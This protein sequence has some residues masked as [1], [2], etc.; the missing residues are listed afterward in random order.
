MTE[1]TQDGALALAGGDDVSQALSVIAEKNSSITQLAQHGRELHEQYKDVAF[2]VAT[3]AGMESAKAA[4]HQI[5]TEAR[6]PMQ[7]LQEEGSKMLGTMQRQFNARA[8][9]L[10]AEV[11]GYEKPID[12]QIKAEEQRKADIKAKAEAEEKLRVDTITA[13]IDAVRNAPLALV[14]ATAG[15]VAN[16]IAELRA[17]ADDATEEEFQ[18]F[19][20]QAK[21]AYIGALEQLQS[22]L[23]AKTA[24]EAAAAEI[25]R[26]QAAQAEQQR[27]MDEQAA[28]LRQ[29][30]EQ[31]AAQQ[32]AIDEANAR[33]EHE[34]QEREQ[35]ILRRIEAMRELPGRLMGAAAANIESNLRTL[36]D[37]LLL[38]GDYGQFL[39]EA[40]AARAAA[41][42]ELRTMHAAQVAREEEQAAENARLERER[43][44]REAAE[45]AQRELDRQAAEA[46]AAERA[47][48][49]EAARAARQKQE[50]LQALS[51]TM[52]GL[53]CKGVELMPETEATA[54]WLADAR[55]LVAQV[56][57]DAPADPDAAGKVLAVVAEVFGLPAGDHLR[58][59]RLAE[60]C[61]ATAEDG[62][63][64]IE[65]LGHAFK[66]DIPLVLAAQIAGAATVQDIIHLMG[67]K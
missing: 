53:L 14:N 29:Q 9:E 51:Q 4:R 17:E 30:Q 66:R 65:E 19:A 24:A 20:S 38:P 43:L 2:D 35:S 28:A 36:N 39:A 5:R 46:A 60:D 61:S 16:A 11:E 54:Q 42:A 62:G 33:A 22:M 34:R 63:V 45:A 23:E 49:E 12:E 6:Y 55:A 7:K 26:Q 13:A 10:I 67:G 8:N 27:I 58:A 48:A 57:G 59:L 31:L 40:E 18:E 50:R 25:E 41:L 44:D 32:R 21:R 56:N 3:T 1:T 52:L 64:L 15:E 37:T 47:R